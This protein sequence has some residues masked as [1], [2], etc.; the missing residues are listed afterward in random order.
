MTKKKKKKKKRK[1]ETLLEYTYK[2]TRNTDRVTRTGEVNQQS[3]LYYIY[4][5]CK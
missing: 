5:Q 3:E 4:I 1:R 2:N